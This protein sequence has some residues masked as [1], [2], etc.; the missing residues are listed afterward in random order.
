MD[1]AK[2][3]VA[4]LRDPY[5]LSLTCLAL[6]NYGDTE[7]GHLAADRLVNWQK[8]DGRVSGAHTTLI[9]MGE[10]ARDVETTRY[11]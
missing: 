1:S 11:V 6:Y 10:T 8:D 5:R 2:A 7:A 3:H 4:Q 9:P